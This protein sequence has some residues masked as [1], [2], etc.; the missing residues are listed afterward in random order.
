MCCRCDVRDGLGHAPFPP[1]PSRD[2]SCLGSVLPVVDSL[3]VNVRD[4]CLHI[5]MLLPLPGLPIFFQG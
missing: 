2:T 1:V 3:G 4:T 5:V